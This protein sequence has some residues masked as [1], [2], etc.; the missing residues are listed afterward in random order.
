M[1]VTACELEQIIGAP[2]SSGAKCRKRKVERNTSEENARCSK[3]VRTVSANEEVPKTLINEVS[4]TES[5]VAANYIENPVLTEIQSILEFRNRCTVKIHGLPPKTTIS[6]L[7]S[8]VPEAK[9]YRLPWISRLHRCHGFAFIEFES[10]EE[11]MMHKERL[12]RQ[13][14]GD[15]ALNASVGKFISE[16]VDDYECTVLVL[17]GLKYNVKRGEIARRFP[18]SID[19]RIH[20]TNDTHKPGV[21]YLTFASEEDALNALKSRQGCFLRGR[22]TSVHFRVKPKKTSKNCLIVRGL[23]KKVSESDLL[24]VFPQAL[25][26]NINRYRGEARL[27][28]DL[29]EDCLLDRKQAKNILIGGRKVDVMAVSVSKKD[30]TRPVLGVAKSV[31]S[32]SDKK[33]SSGIVI[34]KCTLALSEGK[35]REL[36]PNA[37]DYRTFPPGTSQSGVAYVEFANLSHAKRAV[38]ALNGK[39]M[40][41]RI[42]NQKRMRLLGLLEKSTPATKNEKTES[43]S[44]TKAH[45]DNYNDSQGVNNCDIK[46]HQKSKKNKRKPMKPKPHFLEKPVIT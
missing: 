31:D 1:D 4:T 24:A 14:Y 17:H 11:A 23:G 16:C 12:D 8:L 22:K 27:I 43:H 19:I 34:D 35:I 39:S 28:Y 25:T 10:E 6:E 5:K 20:L 38:K 36:F 45:R 13:F 15:R 26:V 2:L 32:Y 3:T 41:V 18:A 44:S 37:V 42:A 9:A 21:A 7:E 29:E 46:R 40:R 30:S 33:A